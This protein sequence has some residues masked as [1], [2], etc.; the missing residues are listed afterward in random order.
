MH[1]KF[2]RPGRLLGRGKD[3]RIKSLSRT[4]CGFRWSLSLTSSFPC[5]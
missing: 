4:D 2:W 1:S 3:V 5:P